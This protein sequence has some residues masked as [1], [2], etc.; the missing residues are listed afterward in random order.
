[1]QILK[2]GVLYF[3]VVFGAGCILGPIL[4]QCRSLRILVNG[5]RIG[6]NLQLVE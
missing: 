5:V 4:I 3:G 6:L 1:M 2:A